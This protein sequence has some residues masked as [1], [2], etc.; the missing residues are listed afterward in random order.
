MYDMFSQTVEYALRAIVFLAD[1]NPETTTTEQIA[2]VTRVPSAYLSKVLQSLSRGGLVRSQRGLRGGFTLTKDPSEMKRPVLKS[3]ASVT[4]GEP[5]TDFRVIV[6][7][8]MIEES[9]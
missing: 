2:E 8:S 4:I 1:R 5:E 3:H 9:L 6:C 7:S